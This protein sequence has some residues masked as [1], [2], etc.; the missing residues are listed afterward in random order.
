MPAS[1]LWNVLG[2]LFLGLAGLAGLLSGWLF[3]HPQSRLNPL[4]PTTAAQ[5]EFGQTLAT[6]PREVS[7]AV[8][9]LRYPTL[10]PE[11]TKIPLPPPTSTRTPRPTF[12]PTVTPTPS[13]TFTPT[14]TLPAQARISGL[15]GHRQTLSLSCE[16]R[17]AADWAA[18]FG[19]TIDEMEFFHRLPM[20]D[21]PE[22]GFVGDV[23]GDW[24]YLPPKAY[25]VHAGPVAN[26]LKAYGAPAQASRGLS[27]EDLQ[28]E[29]AAGR[30]VMV[31]IVGH[32]WAGKPVTYTAESGQ[33]VTVARY[34]HTAILIGYSATRATV[35]DG[36]N[37]YSQPIKAFLRSWSVLGNMAI[38]W[39]SDTN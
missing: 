24:G 26:L 32:L 9:V 6:P 30:P 22:I 34:E 1:R 2:L 16:S 12:T 15:A 33:T 25:G 13:P 27:W 36:E 17:S 35:V 31:W 37:T 14:P 18:Y 3:V 38:L 11:W 19:L 10:P 4:P 28:R 7:P 23:N 21:N 39:R 8:P 20:S 5:G 29:I